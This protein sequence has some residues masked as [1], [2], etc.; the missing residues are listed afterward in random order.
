MDELHGILILCERNRLHSR[1]CL[2]SWKVSY[3][4]IF[5]DFPDSF[6]GLV[7]TSPV[8]FHVGE[9]AS[10]MGP[11]VVLGAK[12]EHRE[13][14]NLVL[15]FLDVWGDVFGM[16][17]FGRPP[18]ATET[19]QWKEEIEA[20]VPG[21]IS[22][23]GILLVHPSLCRRSFYVPTPP[24]FWAPKRAETQSYIPTKIFFKYWNYI[25][26]SKPVISQFDPNNI[27]KMDFLPCFAVVAKPASVWHFNV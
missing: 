25:Y 17:D 4:T 23:T 2:L 7:S 3:F 20:S 15:H 26:K 10:L 22:L 13:L 19:T 12:E 27:L 11:V 1:N 8:S 9:D 21:Y 6:D 16:A 5:E 14:S 18:P 24:L